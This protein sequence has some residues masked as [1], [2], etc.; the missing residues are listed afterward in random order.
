M[1]RIRIRS[2]RPR[3]SIGLAALVL[4]FVLVACSLVGIAYDNLEWYVVDTADDL[5]TLSGEQERTLRSDFRL[6]QDLHR[7]AQLPL[8]IDY[9]ETVAAAV[10]DGLTS[11]EARCVVDGA[12]WLYRDTVALAIPGSARLL[13]SLSSSQQAQ[14]ADSVAEREQDYRKEYLTSDLQRR[15]IQRS[16]RATGFIEYWTGDLEEPQKLSVELWS[17]RAPDSAESW[18]AYR[19]AEISALLALLARRASRT[20]IETFLGRWWVDRAGMSPELRDR[21]DALERSVVDLGLTLD[22]TLTSAQRLHA[23]R[24][25]E[26]LADDLKALLPAAGTVVQGAVA[27]PQAESADGIPDCPGRHGAFCGCS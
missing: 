1:A 26:G 13:G 19:Q 15:R 7:S 3:S 11:R 14:L 24:R 21:V 4:P 22:R 10:G 20:E 5:V 9:L 17:E 16:E 25:F 12:R 6:A 27:A 23:I 18:L 2:T 8:I